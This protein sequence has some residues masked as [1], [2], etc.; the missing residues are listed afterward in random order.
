MTDLT[1]QFRQNDCFIEKTLTQVDKTSRGSTGGVL[2]KEKNE[3]SE[4]DTKYFVK[5]CSGVTGEEEARSE[6]LANKLYALC[7]VEVPETTLVTKEEK[8]MTIYGV[9]SKWEN[10]FNQ[11]VT[12]ANKSLTYPGFAIDAWLNNYDAPCHGNIGTITK[13]GE[14]TAFRIDHKGS[15][16]LRSNPEMNSARTK[17]EHYGPDA[18]NDIVLCIGSLRDAS[19]SREGAALW[20][21]MSD[22]D[23]ELGVQKL[24]AVPR[25]KIIECVKRHGYGDEQTKKE[26]AEQLLAR[27]EYLM[28]KYFTFNKNEF[29]KDTE[30]EVIL[31]A[32]ARAFLREAAPGDTSYQD[33]YKDKCG[34]IPDPKTTASVQRI[35]HG[36]M[37]S[38]RV[39]FLVNVF[40]NLYKQYDSRTDLIDDEFLKML[41][42]AGMFHDAGRDKDA[43]VDCEAWE[44][45][46]QGL[47]E[48]AL[49]ALG[50]DETK[51][52]LVASTIYY[53]ERK[54]EIPEDENP[55]DK[56]KERL[57][58]LTEILHDADS[59]DFLRVFTTPFKETKLNFYSLFVEGKKSE[60]AKNGL[61][62]LL[63]ALKQAQVEMSDSPKKYGEIDG[64]FDLD[65][66]AQYEH[67][68]NPYSK[69]ASE[70]CQ[71]KEL[72][73]LYS[74]F[75][76]IP[77]SVVE[78]N[79]QDPAGDRILTPLISASLLAATSD[80]KKTSQSGLLPYCDVYTE[81]VL[82]T[83]YLVREQSTLF[84]FRGDSRSLNEIKEQGGLHP[85]IT[86]SDSKALEKTQE[87]SEST[88]KI[89]KQ[90]IPEYGQKNIS[91]GLVFAS[92]NASLAERYGERRFLY[93]L[94]TKG[95]LQNAGA[96][97]KSGSSQPSPGE[98]LDNHNLVIPGGV[99]FS[100]VLACYDHGAK[101]LFRRSFISTLS[102]ENFEILV[103]WLLPPNRRIDSSALD[104]FYMPNFVDELTRLYEG[105]EENEK[106]FFESLE[107]KINDSKK[108]AQLILLFKRTNIPISKS[109]E[110]TQNK[111]LTRA[112]QIADLLITFSV[113][114]LLCKEILTAGLFNSEGRE[115]TEDGQVGLNQ[116]NI[117]AK[118]VFNVIVSANYKNFGKLN[119]KIDEGVF[120]V[121]TD[122]EWVALIGNNFEKLVTFLKSFDSSNR[123]ERLEA[124]HKQGLVL[125]GEEGII[126]DRDDL[127]NLLRWFDFSNR[128]EL[129]KAFQEQ[130]LV[131]FGEEGII[132]KRYELTC[133]LEC[134]DS[135]N[136]LERLEAFQEQGL[137]LFGKEG[138][139]KNG[140]DLR[141]LLGSFDSSN[142]LERLEAFQEQG[143]VL[144]GEEG[145]IKK[146]DD[147]TCL[148][149]SFDSSN[150]LELLQ[151]WQRQGLVLFGEKGRVF[152][153][154]CH[155]TS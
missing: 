135:S 35:K 111:L 14:T 23:I 92:F 52:K 1:V 53:A 25:E 105:M 71:Q 10:E 46:S 6:V 115:I 137:V 9:A 151:E 120:K 116:E 107:D 97:T 20:G 150:R 47:A 132:K 5:F 34:C 153:Q 118:K 88:G 148:L 98:I 136:L 100:D 60:R 61:T 7:G 21:D 76:L 45:K 24:A 108:T 58:V 55:E 19:I 104:P 64:A 75:V 26:L 83:N 96:L 3:G 38:S 74:G 109:S 113:N 42:I 142:C 127:I 43:G 138:I 36:V 87:T 54:N 57:T 154:L 125:F 146:R 141:G 29:N 69:I 110:E 44:K 17:T 66:K 85:C 12:P 39:A 112:F 129:L 11:T 82:K 143:L 50:F 93:L 133:L 79:N 49:I 73:K 33:I 140:K 15:F 117:F 37:H 155:R 131:L 123:L 134:F 106:K 84:A 70:L 48:S 122:S 65:L 63:D 56:N 81:D 27:R 28:M 77:V 126:K 144:F 114:L 149:G 72:T 80:D 99:D 41:Q 40:F 68:R 121:L 86:M 90:L 103:Q 51:S 22:A 59:S 130:G 2:Y 13:D 145:I 95:A 18:W 78:N 128:L 8:G 147:L 101:L 102:K 4:A 139:I 62:K 89:L 32:I 124:F 31:N 94:R 30:L 91:S 16:N 119:I 67:D 152:G